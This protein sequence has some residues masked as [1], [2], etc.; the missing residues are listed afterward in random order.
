MNF[1]S[2]LCLFFALATGALC[3]GE[4]KSVPL[5]PLTTGGVYE[6]DGKK[7]E[8]GLYPGGKNEMP[9]P[10]RAA[11]E[12]L[13]ATIVP[14]NRMGNED[15]SGKIVVITMGHSNPQAYFNGFIPFV[16]KKA[17]EG[18]VN[19]KLN[20]VNQCIQGALCQDWAENAKKGALNLEKSAQVLFLVTTFH[21]ANIGATQARNANVLTMSL[22]ERTKAMKEELKAIL[23]GVVKQCPHLTIAY[24]TSEVWRGNAGLEPMVGEEG[25]AFKALIEDQ[26]K[27]D[28]E[29]AYAGP[30]RKVPWLAWGPYVWDPATARERFGPD[31]VHPSDAGV[32]VMCGR[33]WDMLSADSTTKGWFRLK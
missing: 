32:E 8:M 17:G 3:A 30:Q 7:Y 5:K 28:P 24:I 25:F 1:K 2:M 31:G 20:I 19:K 22:E 16:E 12:K 11:G 14:R 18:L 26:I 23:V 29:L 27:G 13:A 4:V 10:H 6:K 33:W 9:A 15:A 21:R